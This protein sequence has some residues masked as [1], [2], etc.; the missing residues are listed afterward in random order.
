MTKLEHTQKVDTGGELWAT[1]SRHGHVDASG[2]WGKIHA[3]GGSQRAQRALE[4][5][6]RG[7]DT[8]LLAGVGNHISEAGCGAQEHW[9]QRRRGETQ[10]L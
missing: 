3:P 9:G 4:T 8:G 6:P 2:R 5:R 10:T 1:A 7:R